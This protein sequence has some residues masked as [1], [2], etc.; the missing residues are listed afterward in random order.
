MLIKGEV[1]MLISWTSTGRRVGDPNQS[2]IIGKAGFGVIPGH[3]VNGKI[4][5]AS[6]N[7]G[8]RSWAVSKYSKV[9]D[10]TALVLDFV[11]LPEQRL[12]IVMDPKTIIDPWR[13]SHFT[14]ERFRSA[15]PGAD[16]YLD[17]IKASFPSTVPGILIPG[18]DEYQ[19]G[20][21]G[22]VSQALQKSI[23]SKEALDQAAEE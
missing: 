12:K 21:A 20:V 14:S 13:T 5:R 19:P 8:G 17:S 4:I 23:S 10:A 11:S 1:P 16:E 15:F 6:P 9:K 22:A 7:T 18:G 3:E 2:L